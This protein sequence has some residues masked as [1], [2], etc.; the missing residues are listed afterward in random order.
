MG[1]VLLTGFF[2]LTLAFFA[3]LFASI[4]A[5]LL[6]HFRVYFYHFYLKITYV[7]YGLQRISLTQG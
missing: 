1:E 6:L 2:F 4:F 3:I 5:L 7:A